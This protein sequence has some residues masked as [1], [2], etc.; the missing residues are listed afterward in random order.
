MVLGTLITDQNTRTFYD[1]T[2]AAGRPRGALAPPPP[3]P[4]PSEFFSDK[5]EKLTV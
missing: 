2:I 3:P 5:I 4:P 1:S